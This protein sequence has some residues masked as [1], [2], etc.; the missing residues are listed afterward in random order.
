MKDSAPTLHP[1][2]E[3]QCPLDIPSQACQGSNDSLANTVMK[4]SP[5]WSR[6]CSHRGDVHRH[7]LLPTLPLS[8]GWSSGR[9]RK[10]ASLGAPE[11]TPSHH[12]QCC[13]P[14]QGFSQ[15][16]PAISTLMPTPSPPVLLPQ[17]CP[18]WLASLDVPAGSYLK[19]SEKSP[20]SFPE[21]LNKTENQVTVNQ[22]VWP[23]TQPKGALQPPGQLPLQSLQLELKDW[24]R[25][26]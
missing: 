20:Y 2:P 1:F 24:S 22:F 18:L 16:S 8:T 3:P 19:S 23:P 26:P 5:T 4:Q 12:H 14:S 11:P 15:L 21:T 9:Y 13:Q 17:P 25:E 7:T 10:G 6:P